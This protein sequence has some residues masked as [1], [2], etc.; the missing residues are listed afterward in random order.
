MLATAIKIYT[1]QV[2]FLEVFQYASLLIRA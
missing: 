1:K 2:S